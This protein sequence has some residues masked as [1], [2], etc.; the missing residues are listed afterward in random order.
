MKLYLKYFSIHLRSLMQ[1]KMSFVLASLS[2]LLGSFSFFLALHFLLSRFGSVGGFSYEEVLLCFAAVIMSFSTAECFFRGFDRFASIIGNGEFDRMM[3]RPRSLVFQVIGS[4]IEFSRLG[5]FLQA[6][7]VFAYVI[8]RCGVVWTGD[9]ILTLVLMLI[10]GILEFAG[11]FVIYASICF[12]ST[13]G[14]EFM[15]IFTDGGREFGS[16]PLSI[17]GEGVLKFYTFVIPMALWSY[18]PLLYLIG[19]TDSILC[20]LAPIASAVFLIPCYILWRIGVR[21]FKSTGS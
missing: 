13:E 8:P 10:G 2:Q 6:L 15:N 19:R 12:F 18:Y 11:L 14:L 20:M 7:I 4:K 5:R 3:V 1:H 17:Y 16:Y 21:H 9:K